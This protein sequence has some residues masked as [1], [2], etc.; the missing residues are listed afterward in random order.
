MIG[1]LQTLSMLPSL[2]PLG[3][4][5]TLV[6]GMFP[7]FLSISMTISKVFLCVYHSV[8]IGIAPSISFLK[9]AYFT[10]D[11]NPDQTSEGAV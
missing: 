7:V 1:N 2:S 6:L 5:W 4:V 3:K 8:L 9:V 11:M 10:K